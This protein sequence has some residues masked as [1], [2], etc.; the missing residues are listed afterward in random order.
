ML[1]QLYSRS[2]SRYTSSPHAADLDAFATMVAARGVDNRRTERHTRRLLWVL[3]AAALPPNGIIGADELRSAFAA[4]PHKGYVGTYRLYCRYLQERGRLAAPGPCQS[5][6]TL[7]EQHLRRLVELRGIAPATVT[8]DNWALTDFLS[9]VLKPHQEPSSITR[10][11]LDA[12][13]RQRGPQL[14]RRT[15]GHTVHVV[16]RYLRYAFD[17]GVLSEPLHEFALPQAFRFE[18]PPRALPAH[19]VQALLASID[20]STNIGVRDHAILHLMA[21]YGLRPGE[22]AA[23]KRSSIDWQAHALRVEQSKTRSVLLIPLAPNTVDV[24]RHHVERWA[25]ASSGAELFGLAQPPFGPMSP[26]AVSARF[27]VHARRSGLP[28]TEASA[29]ALRHSFAMRL[30]GVGVSMKLIGDLMGHSSL[31]STSAYLRIQT[32]M[33][34]E[35]A[36]DVPAEV[37]P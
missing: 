31:A 16:R 3:E 2:L 11:S 13:F 28:I 21:G 25:A 9:R 5:R 24:L 33:L 4:W 37:A 1:K 26:C 19:Q 29:Y 34:R 12:F 32:D 18:Q 30:L 23:L 6:F 14:A 36:L 8:Y 20:R 17:T 35:V 15:F 7:K 27:K 10:Q 22:V